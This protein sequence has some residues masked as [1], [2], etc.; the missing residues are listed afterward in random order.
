[1]VSLVPLLQNK[2]IKWDYTSS[3]FCKISMRKISTP[4]IPTPLKFIRC[5]AMLPYMGFTGLMLRDSRKGLAMI[6]LYLTGKMRAVL[7]FRT[8]FHTRNPIFSNGKREK[9]HGF[10]EGTNTAG[11]LHDHIPIRWCRTRFTAMVV[12]IIDCM[13]LLPAQYVDINVLW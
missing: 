12:Y 4:F 1:M 13:H 3:S 8:G 6:Q 10:N 7:S 9:K 5:K 11:G 2:A